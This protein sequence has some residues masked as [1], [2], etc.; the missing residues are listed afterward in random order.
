M[1]WSSSCRVVLLFSVAVRQSVSFFFVGL[2]VRAAQSHIRRK[3]VDP[4]E[5]VEIRGRNRRINCELWS[6]LVSEKFSTVN[7]DRRQGKMDAW[8]IFCL[9]KD[10]KVDKIELYNSYRLFELMPSS[11]IIPIFTSSTQIRVTHW[12]QVDGIKKNWRW[13]RDFML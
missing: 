7:N 6:N 9:K 5:S 13:I 11:K 4:S 3:R 8:P 12:F 1:R 10:W 2:F